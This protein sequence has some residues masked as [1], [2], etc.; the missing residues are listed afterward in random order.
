MHTRRTQEVDISRIGRRMPRLSSHCR[1]GSTKLRL[2]RASMGAGRPGDFAHP[3]QMPQQLTC[4]RG[5]RS[6]G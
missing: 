5:T 2:S 6:T 3:R 4:G 1:S